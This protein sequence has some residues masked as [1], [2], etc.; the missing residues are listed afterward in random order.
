[1]DHPAVVARHVVPQGV[2]R[3]V[4]VRQVTCGLPLQVAQ[5]TRTLS[6]ERDHPRVDEQLDDCVHTVPGSPDRTGHRGGPHRDRPRPPPGARWGPRNTLPAGAG[7]QRGQRELGRDRATG[8][9][10][11]RQRP[12]RPRVDHHEPTSARCPTCT[13]GRRGRAAPRTA[14]ARTTSPR[15]PPAPPPPRRRGRPARPSRA[16][17]PRRAGDGQHGHT[18]PTAETRTPIGQEVRRTGGATEPSTRS[19]TCSPVTPA[20]SA[21]GSTMSRCATARGAPCCLTSSGTT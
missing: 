21:S 15:G 16:A 18:Q 14:S 10:A 2:E 3:H 8:T 1:M 12:V 13:R 4:R 9:P 7:R 17:D 19:R 11:G 20:N 6:P 5:Q